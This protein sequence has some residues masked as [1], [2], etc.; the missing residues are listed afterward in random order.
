MPGEK[1]LGA[2]EKINNRA[3]LV[4]G[5]FSRHSATLA[6]HF[7]SDVDFRKDVET[8]ADVTN[9]PIQDYTH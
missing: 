2:R 3:T 4:G 1:P 7:D 9:N 6:T 8:S 5:E